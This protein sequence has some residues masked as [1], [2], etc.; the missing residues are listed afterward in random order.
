MDRITIINTIGSD[1]HTANIETGEYSYVLEA[2][3]KAELE[4]KLGYSFSHFKLDIRFEMEDVVVLV[5][6][7]QNFAKV[8]EEQIAEYLAEERVLHYGKKIIAILAN[9]NDDKIKVWKSSVD[10]AHVL[11]DETVFDKMEHYAKLFSVNKQNDREK[12]LKNT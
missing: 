10:D 9:T 5:E 11:S 1:Y 6:T 12:V 3:S 4:K 2:G 8:D 7:K